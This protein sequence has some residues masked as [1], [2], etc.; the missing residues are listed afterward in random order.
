M[1]GIQQISCLCENGPFFS[2]S[3]HR[4]LICWLLALT[5]FQSDSFLVFG[6]GHDKYQSVALELKKCGGFFKLKLINENN[7]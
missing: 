1:P 5:N 3:E 4:Q 2:S 6:E 7:F